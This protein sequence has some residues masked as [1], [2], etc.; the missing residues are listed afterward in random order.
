MMK[1]KW[2]IV[3]MACLG[4]WVL[5]QAGFAGITDP[6]IITGVVRYN[7][8]EGTSCDTNPVVVKSGL[9]NGA[10]THVDRTF[11][12]RDANDLEGIDFVQTAVDDKA[13]SA[14]QMD[15]TVSKA[16]T[17]FLLI[18]N[19]V[20]DGNG[21]NPPTIGSVMNWVLTNGFVQTGYTV[22]VF[23]PSDSSTV[24]MTAYAK[25]I[26]GA[27]TISLYEQNDGTSR[28]TYLIAAV[29]AG[30]NLPPSVMGVPASAQVEPGKSL[31]IDATIMDYGQNTTTTVL[32]EKVSGG[33]VVFSPNNTSE[34]VSVSFPGG[35]GNYTLQLTVTDG[36]GKKTV[37]TVE[38]AVQIKSYAL[39]AADH[40][41]IGN[42]S[43]QGP[44][45]ARKATISDVKNFN[46]GSSQRR[47]VCYYRYNIADQKEAGKVFA[48]S[49]LMLNVDKGNLYTTS[50]VYVY[51]IKEE[52]DNFTLQGTTWSTAPGVDNAPVPPLNSAITFDTL[53]LEDISPLL[54]AF[55][56]PTLDIWL[57]TAK[58][59]ALDEFLNSDTDGSVVLMFITYDPESCG[60]EICSPSHSRTETETGLKGIILRGNVATPTWATKPNPAN[61]TSQS[62]RLAQLSWTNPAPSQEGAV[63]TCDVF[64]GTTEPNLLDPDY[65]LTTLATGI[66]G[67]S[68][69]IPSGMLQVNTTYYWVV[70]VHDSIAGTTRGFV[71]TFNT[72]NMIPLVEL[73]KP[74]Q[75]IWLNN[76]GN[77]ATAT[78]VI[79]T[80]VTD[81]NFPQPYTLL[82]EQLSG[83][84]TV[85]IVPNNVEDITLVLPQTGT[86]VFRLSADDGSVIG[87]AS[88]QIYVGT[89][90]CNAAQAKPTYVRIPADINNDCF[91]DMTDLAE[92]VSR[93]L[94]C[95]ASMEAPCR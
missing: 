44:T 92:F 40:C 32:W 35:E 36:E 18:D 60:F 76:A 48:N 81:D 39:A 70:D 50:H 3:S 16:G 29:P 51:G 74:S 67:N 55:T 75:Y 90:P 64:L 57:S 12:F 21:A 87:S 25:P 9:L 33:E 80:T 68:V 34:D 38:V 66:S 24:Y 7:C 22:G 31:V 84:V 54:A 8:I 45:S 23:N 77:P 82:W 46:D 43:S 88:T 28:I 69:A 62:T 86:Y 49:Y 10:L 11:V 89:S 1:S 26:S 5:A 6:N 59:P 61:N 56:V 13:N 53:D 20:G 63:I 73:E 83:P 2:V 14:L 58:F 65:G 47:R 94:E 78:A 52:Y 15:V 93:W 79:N 19:R 37:K 41:E 95:N 27:G 85:P 72:N 42:D 17:L 4:L 71:W 91:V 30:W